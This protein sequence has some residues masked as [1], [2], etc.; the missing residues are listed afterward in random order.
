MLVYGSVNLKTPW[1][2]SQPPRIPC[3]GTANAAQAAPP[4]SAN[5]TSSVSASSTLVQGITGDV[6]M[7]MDLGGFGWF[8]LPPHKWT[9]FF[10]GGGLCWRWQGCVCFFWRGFTVQHHLKGL[11]VDG[12][13]STCFWV[14]F[15]FGGGLDDIAKS[16]IVVPKKA[17]IL[18]M[19]GGVNLEVGQLTPIHHGGVSFLK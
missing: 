15:F 18:M 17:I 6:A 14:S 10:F 16:C 2:S 1:T 19:R 8:C 9:C 4:G 3:K 12:F 7:K 5:A 11:L 13:S